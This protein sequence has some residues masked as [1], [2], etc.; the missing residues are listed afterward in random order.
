M[1]LT[2]LSE[3][4]GKRIDSDYY[5]IYYKKIIWCI[6]GSYY[7]T[8]TIGKYC[9][10]ISGYAFSSNDYIGQSDCILITIKNI[11]KNIITLEEKTFLPSQYYEMYPKFR[12]LENDLLIA[13]TGATI[14]KVGIYNSC[15]KSLLNQRNGIIRSKN[16]NTFY[17]MNL[18]NL[19]IYQKLILRSSVGGAQPNISG[20]EILKINI[21]IPSLQKQNEIATHI[22]QIRNKAN[23]L[24]QEG[25]GILEQAKQEVEQMIFG[26]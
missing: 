8:E 11:S 22:S 20:K 10:F 23:A 4:T 1:F 2:N 13:M 16:L 26:N 7:K 18:L 12:V 21:P 24:K 6:E 14:G 5:S 3:V 9:G 19:A 25:K 15:E 17:L